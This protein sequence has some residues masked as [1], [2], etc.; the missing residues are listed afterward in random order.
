MT[1]PINRDFNLPTWD[2]HNLEVEKIASVFNKTTS[3]YKFWWSLSILDAIEQNRS[4]ISINELILMMLSKAYSPYATYHFFFGLQDIL[5]SRIEELEAIYL[6][7]LKPLCDSLSIPT[8][9]RGLPYKIEEFFSIRSLIAWL[10]PVMLAPN[11]NQQRS[12]LSYYHKLLLASVESGSARF[13]VKDPD[14]IAIASIEANPNYHKQLQELI[15]DL[16]GYAKA[17]SK[18][19]IWVPDRFLSPWNGN[20]DASDLSNMAP[21]CIVPATDQISSATTSALGAADAIATSAASPASAAAHSAA[22]AGAAEL[23]ASS[24]IITDLSRA[25]ETPFFGVDLKSLIERLVPQASKR[26]D[27]IVVFNPL[28]IGYL[29]QNLTVLRSFTYQRLAEYMEKHNRLMPAIVSKLY[30]LEEKRNTLKI[31][32]QYFESYIRE[33]G[34]L[35]CIY[36][37]ERFEDQSSYALDHFIPWSFV[38]HDMIWNLT[39]IDQSSNSSKSNNLPSLDFIEDLAKQHQMLLKFHFEKAAKASKSVTQDRR[40]DLTHDLSC[41]FT[42]DDQDQ[43]NFTDRDLARDNQLGDGYKIIVEHYLEISKGSSIFDLTQMS[44]PNFC[45][46]IAKE[47]RP[48]YEVA[49]NQG[50]KAWEH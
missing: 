2:G 40:T 48:S 14:L 41:D 7:R 42:T 25:I 46:L 30:E 21:Y 8:N 18:L 1:D 33:R 45:D 4:T 44:A 24:I 15:S 37:H 22:T 3:S 12:L 39:P 23:G 47:I 26:R 10:L 38:H 16:Q 36:N 29:K 11:K 28:Y 34:P 50:F 9:P 13:T 6:T 43:G 32:H 5:P 19:R 17:L 20:N 49:L 27:D 35:Q 31:Q